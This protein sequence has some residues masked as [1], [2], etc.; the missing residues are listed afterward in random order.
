MNRVVR[1]SRV[2]CLSS[3]GG[4][5]EEC[6]VHAVGKWVVACPL[7]VGTVLSQ[8]QVNFIYMITFDVSIVFSKLSVLCF[9]LRVFT[10]RSMRLVTQC[11]IAI[12]T[13]WGI[14][15]LLQSLLVCRIRDGEIDAFQ[16]AKCPGHNE[17]LIAVGIFNSSTHLIVCLLPLY[18][19]WSFKTISIST[20]IGLSAVCLLGLM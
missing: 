20:R 2:R 10:H 18:T 19:I 5:Y 15:N 12:V 6:S 13:A 4:E 7:S 14:G 16:A 1:R 17:S 9:Y 8:R 11:M 3:C